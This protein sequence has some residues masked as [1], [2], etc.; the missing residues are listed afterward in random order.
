MSRPLLQP[1]ST[2]C[3]QSEGR[4]LLLGSTEPRLWTPPLRDLSEPGASYGQWVIEFATQVLAEPLDPWQAWLVVHAGELLPDG[5]PRFRRVLALVA[6]QNGKTHLLRT[7][8]LYWV[9]VER[10][11]LTVGTSTNLD[12]ARESWEAAVR[13]AEDVEALSSLLPANG[14]RRANGEQCLTTSDRCRYKIAAS[15]RKGGRSLSIDRLI[16][17]ELREQHDWSAY[18]AAYPAMNARPYGQAW[19]ISNQGDDRSVVLDALRDGA[20]AGM[21][22]PESGD[23]RLGLFEWSA[24]DGCDLM[25]PA[26][27]V[28][29]NPN[30]G[31]RL[32]E[33]TVRGSAA[34]AKSNGGEEEAGYRTEVLCQR[35]RN[36]DAAIDPAAWVRCRDEGTLDGEREYLTACIDIS[37]DC[38]HA[39]LAVAAAMSDGR[40]RVE[41]VAAWDG[42]GCPGIMQR[43]LRSWLLRIRPRT[44]GW[45]PA[46]PAA[47]LAA[48]L[49][50][51]G[52]LMIPWLKITEIQADTA[53]VCMGL[54]RLVLDERIAHS[55]DP[56]LDA[57]V[58][59]AEKLRSGDRWTFSRRRTGHVDSL[60]AVAGATHLARSIGPGVGRPRIIRPARRP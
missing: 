51:G 15:N 24:L 57:H 4:P 7:L 28:A 34:L 54:A 52:H 2:G 22:S 8:A 45:F 9:F 39:T 11:P 12:Y 53:A 50:G 49:R 60:Y 6:R 48:E 21:D 36:L 10:W 27:W 20:L 18:N 19:F 16:A 55:G 46:G 56:L 58:A 3:E 1:L 33:D 43:E 29:A 44:L 59:A 42:L 31:R 23:K 14:V 41:V 37:P 13:A 17:D 47:A 38:L 40:T 5:R 25:D 26:A 35:V 30:L 32:D